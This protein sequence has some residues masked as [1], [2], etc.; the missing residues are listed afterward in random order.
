MNLFPRQKPAESKN[1]M[2]DENVIDNCTSFHPSD[3]TVLSHLIH[4]AYMSNSTMIVERAI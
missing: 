4:I 3:A 1:S 2:Y